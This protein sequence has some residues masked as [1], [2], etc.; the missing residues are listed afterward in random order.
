MLYMYMHVRVSVMS[1]VIICEF[2]QVARVAFADSQISVLTSF[3][4][5]IDN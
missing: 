1:V 2:F 3:G 5:H 4:L